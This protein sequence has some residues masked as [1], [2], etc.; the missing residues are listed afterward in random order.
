LGNIFIAFWYNLDIESKIK[1]CKNEISQI[2]ETRL[3]GLGSGIWRYA[4]APD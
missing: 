3:A 2:R 1:E 4:A